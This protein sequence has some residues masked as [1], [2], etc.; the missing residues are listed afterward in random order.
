MA[1]KVSSGLVIAK[2]PWAAP[3][4]TGDGPGLKQKRESRVREAV[5][6]A[7]LPASRPHHLEASDQPAGSHA[8]EP[9]DRVDPGLGPPRL[10]AQARGESSCL[11]LIQMT[12]GEEHTDGFITHPRRGCAGR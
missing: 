5:A 11:S 9:P 3:I 12:A 4:A 6:L 8:S 1:I 10:A 2:A 7:P